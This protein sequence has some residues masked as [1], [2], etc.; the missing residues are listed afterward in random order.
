[1]DSA[2][3]FSLRSTPAYSYI[4][5]IASSYVC[6]ENYEGDERLLGNRASASS[7]KIGLGSELE[8]SV[9]EDMLGLQLLLS[10]MDG[11]G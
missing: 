3:R 10:V 8:L 2:S 6:Q 5:Y 7:S 9:R 1:M 4:Y 11:M